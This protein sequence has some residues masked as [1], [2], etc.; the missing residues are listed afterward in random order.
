[1]WGFP[2]HQF[3]QHQ[4]RETKGISLRPES[5]F[6]SST[7]SYVALLRFPLE[8]FSFYRGLLL[9]VFFNVFTSYSG[10]GKIHH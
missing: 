7:H 6:P 9:T 3:S 4:Q 1:M 5:K 10:K 2:Q 8:N